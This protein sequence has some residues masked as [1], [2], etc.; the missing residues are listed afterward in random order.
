[1]ANSLLYDTLR[2][3]GVTDESLIHNYEKE[4]N[5]N[6][7]NIIIHEWNMYMCG[8]AVRHDATKNTGIMVETNDEKCQFIYLKSDSNEEF[9]FR[10]YDISGN[11]VEER[12]FQSD[13]TADFVMASE[14][15]ELSWTI[16]NGRLVITRI[17][18]HD[19]VEDVLT[20]EYKKC[21]KLY[22]Y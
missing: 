19:E 17:L 13:D 5:K 21:Y 8:E 18:S 7:E 22:E 6:F 10:W 11:K 12:N 2:K 15:E 1:M 16:D 20:G 9:C 14:I 3:I 4:W